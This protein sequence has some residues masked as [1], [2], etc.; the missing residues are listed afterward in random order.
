MKRPAM[1]I[2]GATMLLVIC[3]LCIPAMALI[4]GDGATWDKTT[5][6]GPDAVVP[7]WYIN[8]GITGA[9]AKI[10]DDQPKILE[11]MYVFKDTPAAAVGGLRVGD[12]IIGVNGRRFTT[13]HKFG[14]GVGKFGYEGP[15]MEFGNALEASVGKTA[16]GKLTIEVVRAGQNKRVDL[17]LPMTYGQYSK[18]Y[19]YN[20]P[21]SDRIMLEL[22]NYLVRKQRD[23]GMWSGRPHINAF[24][25]LALMGS[26]RREYMPAVKK[27]VQAMAKSTSSEIKIGGLP[28]WQ[29]GLYG[30]ALSEYYLLTGEKWVPG[31]LQEISE[32][33]FKAQAPAG[34]WGHGP[35]ITT[36]AKG[37]GYGP[38]CVITMQCKM[39]WSLMQ[40]CKLKVDPKRFQAAHTFAVKGTNSFGYVWYKDGGAGNSGYADMG[41]TGAAALAHYLSPSGGK[42]Y[43]DYAKRAAKCIGD[44]PKT[45]PDT[46]GSPLLG[47]AWTALGAAVDPPSFRKLMDHNRWSMAMA[48]CPDGTFYYQPNRDNNA[49]DYS[50]DPR[51]AASA[52]TALILSLKNRRLQMTG[53]T[54]SGSEVIA[55]T[56]EAITKAEKARKYEQA[57]QG[58]N[59]LGQMI[60]EGTPQY[61][62]YTQA[63]ERLGLIGTK[64]AE[65]LAARSPK[66][67]LNELQ[68]F[69]KAWSGCKGL[70]P[71]NKQIDIYGQQHLTK[72][73]A[74]R[75]HGAESLGKFIKLWSDYPVAETARKALADK[76]QEALTALT[77]PKKKPTILKLQA[78]ERRWS[79]TPAAEKAKSLAN[80]LALVDLE[81]ILK[82]RPNA[83]M[84][85]GF[86]KRW[87]GYD[88]CEQAGA[89]FGEK[90][91]PLL[92]TIDAGKDVDRAAKLKRFATTWAPL[93]I[94]EEA[95]TRRNAVAVNIL[96]TINA[97]TSDK[98]KYYRLRSFIRTYAD[99]PSADTAQKTLKEL[100]A[101]LRT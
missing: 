67:S 54:L 6:N 1:S 99:T 23:N 85:T 11:V 55:A 12:K 45:F 88:V 34:G 4:S 63:V 80:E 35:W 5:S 36:G 29:Y 42:V 62:F 39:A 93:P 77:S 32:W 49:Q 64:L 65:D 86:L 76:G 24:A 66:A 91:K 84:Y 83:T 22:C 98:L 17:K 2:C 79:G 74:G 7:G 48:H 81:R 14:Y 68:K 90:I 40:R 92:E 44:H 18:T 9:R 26:G 15:M 47:M 95:H 50:A 10:P 53:A 75:S 31:E 100:T 89:K 60:F 27:A 96:A 41:R 46:H 70:D 82:L 71:V 25:A 21:K 3:A 20:C 78:F 97:L 94:A 72:L 101:T 58:C 13:A 57:W 52:A 51:L 69:A 38:I 87:K 33:M 61:P 56:V 73:L 37:N 8:L 59:R 19:P 16:A 30:A 43:Y 28:A